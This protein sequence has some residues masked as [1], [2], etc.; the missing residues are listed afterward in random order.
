MLSTSQAEDAQATSIAQFPATCTLER[1]DDFL[2]PD[3]NWL[4]TQCGNQKEYF[5]LEIVDRT[6]KHWSVQY[7]DYGPGGLG[8]VYWTADQAYLFFDST[9]GYEGG[10]T[11]FYGF[12]TGALYRIEL[13]TGKVSTI[14]P[15]TPTVDG[16][17]FAFSPTGRRL[18]YSGSY[19]PVILDLRTGQELNLDVGDD[20]FG[21]LTW[22][23]DGSELAYSTYR[24]VQSGN[25][26]VVK[27][28]AIKIYSTLRQTTRTIFDLPDNLLT[29]ED[30]SATNG[31]KIG[32][33]NPDFNTNY[34]WIDPVSGAQTII[35]PQ[36]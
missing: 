13:K 36:P 17:L 4:A 35:N 8:P 6:G 22:S 14:L 12:G 2:S 15:A 11:C 27:S 26:Y 28:S 31:L 5:N 29:I 10:G 32:S 20:A 21:Y 23:P 18:A 34:L 33:Q 30:W 1:G 3:E 9:V 7:K 25:D 19:G 24:S 16:Y